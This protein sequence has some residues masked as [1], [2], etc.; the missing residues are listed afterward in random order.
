MGGYR[1]RKINHEDARSVNLPIG[2][3][4]D[5]KKNGQ[6]MSSNDGWELLQYQ[7]GQEELRTKV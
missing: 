3:Y 6:R 2:M 4:P 7:Y 5:F 1:G